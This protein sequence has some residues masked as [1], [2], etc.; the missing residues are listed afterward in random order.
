MY[1]CTFCIHIKIRCLLNLFLALKTE[2]IYHAD[3]LIYSTFLHMIGWS[4]MNENLP[5]MTPCTRGL[6]IT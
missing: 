5:D 3:W 1:T 6:D 4:K 2:N